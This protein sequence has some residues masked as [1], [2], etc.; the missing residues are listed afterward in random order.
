MIKS[1]YGAN[2]HEKKFTHGT[3]MTKIGTFGRPKTLNGPPPTLQ[4][5]GYHQILKYDKKTQG[6]HWG[7]KIK[8]WWRTGDIKAT[9]PKKTF[10]CWVKSAEN[11]PQESRLL[12][13]FD[14]PSSCTAGDGS[15][16]RS[17]R[18]MGAGFCNF[19]SLEWHTKQTLTPNP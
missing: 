7:V 8:G 13:A 6:D 2:Q 1:H 5:A 17:T 16:D 3:R 15:C 9:K 12:G 19:R 14:F 11:M 10:E 4:A 18:A